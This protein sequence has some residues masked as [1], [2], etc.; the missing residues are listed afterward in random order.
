MYTVYIL[1]SLL[2]D[3]Y[4]IGCTGENIEERIRKHLSNH[5][6]FTSHFKDW[7][8]VYSEIFEN[9]SDAYSREKE[10]K[11]WKSK[12]RISRL[13]FAGSVHPAL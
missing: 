6:G 3:K 13:I 5:K 8:L 4:Y 10:I 2:G 12:L 9:K 11:S 7:E 1:Y